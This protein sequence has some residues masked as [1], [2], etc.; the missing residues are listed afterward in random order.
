MIGSAIKR[1][2][3]LLAFI[4]LFWFTSVHAGPMLIKTIQIQG[5]SKTAAYVIERE[6]LIQAGQIYDPDLLAE[7][8]QWIR[9]LRIVTKVGAS[10]TH[11][12]DG[13]VITIEMEEKWTTIPIVRFG[14]GGGTAFYV[15]G[16]YDI[17]TFGRLLELGGQ[18][19]NLGGRDAGVIW[20]RDPRFLNQQLR[21]GAEV[22]SIARNQDLH[23]QTGALAGAYTLNRQRLNLFAEK[24][25]NPY[26]IL[27]VALEWD[28]DRLHEQDLS[29]WWQEI[30]DACAFNLSDH[31]QTLTAKVSYQLGR[32]NYQDYLVSG[33]SSQWSMGITGALLNERA[34]R[35]KVTWHGRWFWRVGE[36]QN[37][38]L[39][40]KWGA[41][42]ARILEQQFLLGGLQDIRGYANNQFIGR[43]F[44]QAN[45]EYRISSLASDWL[46][47]QHVVFL[48]AVKT[49]VQGRA[50]LGSSPGPFYSTGLGIRLISPR[51][52]R[53]V[54][55]VDLAQTIGPIDRLGVAFGVQQFF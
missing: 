23:D 28:D 50:L 11:E 12:A 45:L 24:E 33:L 47:V 21:V 41:T 3:C 8:L 22:W 36:T 49:A 9:N 5:L 38:G 4:F 1:S 26:H 29:V 54:L 43:W 42:N 55:R 30:N 17:N 40:A 15:L 14:G 6:L 31:Y 27:G 39:N 32:L 44:W 20:F 48:D 19:E 18:Y 51:I 2:L 13:V 10:T 35:I 7:S 37:I 52:Y 16:L 53:F 34:Q 46:V 25:I